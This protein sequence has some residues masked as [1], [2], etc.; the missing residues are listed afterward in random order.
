MYDFIEDFAPHLTRELVQEAF[1]R[2]SKAE[3]DDL[4]SHLDLPVY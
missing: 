1:G 3:L 2:H 4:F